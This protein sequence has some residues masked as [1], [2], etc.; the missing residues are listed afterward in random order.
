LNLQLMRWRK[1][2]RLKV[3]NDSNKKFDR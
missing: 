2:W 1:N 3:K